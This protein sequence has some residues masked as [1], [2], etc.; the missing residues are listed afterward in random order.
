MYYFVFLILCL[1]VSSPLICHCSPD[2]CY[3][4]PTCITEGLCIEQVIGS[5]LTSTTQGCVPPDL[6]ASTC[7][8]YST[9]HRFCCD[10]YL[11]NNL[12]SIQLLLTT[13]EFPT[14][15]NPPDYITTYYNDYPTSDL[16]SAL[17]Q[18]VSTLAVLII[19]IVGCITAFIISL[20]FFR[21]W[22]RKYHQV[23]HLEYKNPPQRL[24]I[25]ELS[26]DL[27]STYGTGSG[28]GM[29]QLSQVTIAMQVE[30]KKLIG[31]GRYGE[32]WQGVW[33]DQLVAVKISYSQDA[34]SWEAET[35]I[36]MTNLIRHENILG[37][38]AADKIDLDFSLQYWLITDYMSHGSLLDFLYEHPLSLRDAL[39][40]GKGA[41][42]GLAHL[43]SEIKGG[44][45]F[46]SSEGLYKPCIIHRDLKS[47]NILVS[48]TGE[49]VIGDFGLAIRYNQDSPRYLCNLFYK[50][51]G[52][53]RYLSPELMEDKV[54][55]A[56]ISEIYKRA[57]V[58]SLC[59]VLWE[60]FR[61]CVTDG[62][63]DD[64]ELPYFSCVSR[65][66]SFQEMREMILIRDER[67]HIPIRWSQSRELSEV[68]EI[69]QECW[70]P[71]R[72]YNNSI[73][74]LIAPSLP[75][76]LIKKRLISL[77]DQLPN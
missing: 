8:V 2:S 31:S 10:T 24:D 35:H 72:K 67:P 70:Q 39:R 5:E 77:Y 3:D 57:D 43:H 48:S 15:S 75:S 6:I 73:P 69:I 64:C 38:V 21:C 66:P 58:Y 53:K 28:S 34:P 19:C 56:D 51:E 62:V 59:L 52:T 18:V 11:C 27:D 50:R 4:Y 61:R 42:A 32:V 74:D 13:T 45:K 7:S 63:C 20:T 46:N 12:T 37:F 14:T 30:K 25:D 22:W 47:K 41:A 29:A 55:E 16:P 33:R 17:V 68:S 60:I 76:L 44:H 54:E 9:I 23:I 65:E 1:P 36:Y 71:G 40:L 49:A 26:S